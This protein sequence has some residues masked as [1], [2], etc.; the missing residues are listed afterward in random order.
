MLLFLL[1]PKPP[2]VAVSLGAKGDA[3]LG[4][5]DDGNRAAGAAT[6]PTTT[7]APPQPP[8]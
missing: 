1:G 7:P 8:S 2:Q 6:G 4:D 3:V 5:D